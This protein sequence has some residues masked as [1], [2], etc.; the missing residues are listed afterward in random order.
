MNPQ[1]E[2]KVKSMVADIYERYMTGQPTKSEM[3]EL[4]QFMDADKEW[5]A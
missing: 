2:I 3:E 1:K 4:M 5:V